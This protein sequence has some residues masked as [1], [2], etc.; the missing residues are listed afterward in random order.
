MDETQCSS[1]ESQDQL[2]QVIERSGADLQ[3]WMCIPGAVSQQ[4]QRENKL[5]SA[6]RLGFSDQCVAVWTF[7]RSHLSQDDVSNHRDSFAIWATFYFA[8]KS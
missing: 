8:W 7:M 6:P 2:S 1:Q 3:S 4:M 5:V